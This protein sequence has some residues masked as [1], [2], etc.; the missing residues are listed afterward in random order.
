MDIIPKWKIFVWRLLNKAIG[1]SSNLLKRNISVQENC[2]LCQTHKETVSHLSRDCAISARV[3]A[4]STLGIKACSVPPPPIEE[5]IKNFLKLFWKEDGIKS[6]RSKDFIATLWAIWLH[7]NNVVFSNLNENP[8]SILLHK[9][10][11]LKELNEDSK[12][13][14]KQSNIIHNEANNQ[15]EVEVTADH[16]QREH[17]II[18]VDGA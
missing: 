4:C 11:L 3:L 6:E 12:I 9:D 18:L 10:A 8:V 2:Y 15:L 14:D 17:C 16:N 13:R 1:T 7:R 5:W